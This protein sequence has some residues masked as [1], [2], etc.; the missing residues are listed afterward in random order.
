M[1]NL[2]RWTRRAVVAPC[3]ADSAAASCFSSSGIGPVLELGRAP[4]IGLALGALELDPRLLE[5]LLD[6][7]HRAE[8]LLLALPLGVHP[9]RGLALLGER[10]LELLAARGR[11]GIVVVAER[12]Q[13]DLELHDVPVDLVDLGRL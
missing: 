7:G 8:R 9:G 2:G 3:S 12:L 10:P 6:V 13:L 11:A 5:A 1:R 4:E